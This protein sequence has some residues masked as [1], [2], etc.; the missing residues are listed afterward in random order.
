M[1]FEKSQEFRAPFSM[2]AYEIARHANAC[3]N[4]KSQHGHDCPPWFNEVAL[5]ENYTG[6]VWRKSSIPRAGKRMGSK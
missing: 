1:V 6:Y 4:Y 3:A 5:M 2:E